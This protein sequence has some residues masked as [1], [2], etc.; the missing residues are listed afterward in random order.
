MYPP[1]DARCRLDIEIAS[2]PDHHAA[3][4]YTGIPPGRH[5][6]PHQVAR[7]EPFNPFRHIK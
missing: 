4:I 5:L 6:D 7:L 3:D 2:G 1:R